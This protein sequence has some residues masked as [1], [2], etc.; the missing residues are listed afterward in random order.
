MHYLKH[1]NLILSVVVLISLRTINNY[2]KRR[3]TKEV[4]RNPVYVEATITK[5]FPNTPSKHSIV[6]IEVDYEFNAEKV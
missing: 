3:V 5:I 6:N 1:L 2:K 4:L